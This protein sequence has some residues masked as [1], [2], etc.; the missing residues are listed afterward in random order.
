MR[1]DLAA[2]RMETAAVLSAL[3]SGP[4]HIDQIVAATGMSLSWCK[5]AL[6]ALERE[7]KVERRSLQGQKGRHSTRTVDK[8]RGPRIV[9]AER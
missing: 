9:W 7:G 1:P 4:R 2:S 5:R 8:R 6:M 3:S